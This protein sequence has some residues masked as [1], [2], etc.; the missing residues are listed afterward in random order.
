MF[1]NEASAVSTAKQAAALGLLAEHMPDGLLLVSPE[2]RVLYAN[3]A[4]ERMFGYARAEL[5]AGPLERLLPHGHAEAHAAA[6]AGHLAAPERRAMA[7]DREIA[8]RRR[9]GT[10]IAVDVR[11]GPM[12][13][14]G[15]VHQLAVVRDVDRERRRSEDAH[16]TH[17]LEEEASLA[18]IAGDARL[19]MVTAQSFGAAP[20]REAS[21][22]V[23][24]ELVKLYGDALEG[25]LEQR[26][27]RV[28]GARGVA[29]RALVERLGFL[30]AR[31]RD[32][33]E[34]HSAAVDLRSR[35]AAAAKATAYAEE[36]RLLLLE[37][38]G[39][40][41]THYR[42]LSLGRGT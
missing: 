34:V 10:L 40:L 23:F 11:I 4:I 35:A 8:G 30:W 36:A 26:A 14:D 3:A 2:G 13:I 42:K 28:D 27:Y 39:S 16:R 5:E 37:I 25:A 15:V 17:R 12:E 33:V 6:R 22:E 7:P 32:L 21:P 20:L 24:A 1:M 9:D 41:C 38:M 29:I 18:R 19:P 31:P